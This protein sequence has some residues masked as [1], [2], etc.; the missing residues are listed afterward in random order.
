MQR[1]SVP[2]STGKLIRNMENITFTENFLS[3]KEHGGFLFVSP[4]FQKLEDQILPE[5]PFLFGILIHKL[6]IPWAKVFPI[7][8]M[9]RMGAEYGGKF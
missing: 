4:S 9:L 5:N 1:L 3:N 7:R 2:L 8:L 6:E